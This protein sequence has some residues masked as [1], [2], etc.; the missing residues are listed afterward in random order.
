MLHLKALACNPAASVAQGHPKALL[1]QLKRSEA[2]HGK[3]IIFQ[4]YN[5]G[6][7]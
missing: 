2:E 6:R 4:Q 3:V 1:M 5:A 7:H